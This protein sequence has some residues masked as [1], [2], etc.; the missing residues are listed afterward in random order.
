MAVILAFGL[1]GIIMILGFL[2][3]YLFKKTGIPDILILIG[4]G[5]FLGPLMK[6]IDPSLLQP[7]SEIFISLALLVILF[8]SGLN[9]DL[10]KV[11]KESP[12]AMLLALTEFFLSVFFT[13]TFSFFLFKYSWLE[14]LLLGV[15]IGGT[16]SAVVIPLISKVKVPEEVSTLLSL[17]SIFTDAIVVIIGIT[18]IN[19]LTAGATES[20][21]QFATRGIVSAFSIAIVFG[22]IVGVIWLKML[23]Y[24]RGEVYDDIITLAI[25]ILFYAV[26]ES[27]NGNGAIFA[28]TFGLVLGN[29]K[30]ISKMLRSKDQVEAGL[31]MKKFQSEI[32]FFLKTFFFV[33]LGLI[34]FVEDYFI[35]ISSIV[36]SFILLFSRY[37]T[38]YLIS[39]KDYL[40][41]LNQPIMTFMIPRGL[42]AAVLAQ[43]VIVSGLSH[44][45]DFC[46]IVITVIM[47]TVIISAVGTFIIAKGA[48]KSP[49]LKEKMILKKLEKEEK[50]IEKIKK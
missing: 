45:A 30:S 44:L 20:T 50:K 31:I 13:T 18:L 29:G 11:I 46:D 5:I 25:A 6:Y 1:A 35:F 8:D 36:L 39:L 43:L 9:M 47:S 12:K 27:L 10:Y 42:S 14:S 48:F 40:L 3:N 23:K 17:E 24:I 26:V 38:T 4:V 15:I 16:S 28:L 7:I 19:L 33:Y 2:G 37:I 32:S 21:I 41:K 34:F 49:F 22:I